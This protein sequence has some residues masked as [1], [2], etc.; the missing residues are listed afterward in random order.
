[1]KLLFVIL[2]HDRPEAAAELA[3]TLV[4]AGSDATALVHYTCVPTQ[5]WK[6]GQH[7]HGT[8]WYRHLLEA[9]E[10]CAIDEQLVAEEIRR[11]HVAPRLLDW[12][13]ARVAA[14]R[15]AL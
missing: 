10:S 8:V 12:A 13:R 3:R 1:M 6:F 14:E 4:A 5:P 7:R 15:R 9:L 2:A 11:G